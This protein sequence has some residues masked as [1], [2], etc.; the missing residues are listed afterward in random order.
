MRVHIYIVVEGGCYDD[1]S[2]STHVFDFFDFCTLPFENKGNEKSTAA[3][4]RSQECL[5]WSS[6]LFNCIWFDPLWG[7]KLSGYFSRQRI[8]MAD[9]LR[10]S[11]DENKMIRHA[12]KTLRRPGGQPRGRAGV[13]TCDDPKAGQP[14]YLIGISD[15]SMQLQCFK[16]RLTICLAQLQKW[17]W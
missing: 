14:L 3:L 16:K 11:R 4:L 15:C 12:G 9:V 5:A 7:W 6:H 17:N 13:P 10:I 1:D 8:E 2:I